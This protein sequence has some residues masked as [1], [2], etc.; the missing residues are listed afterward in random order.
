MIKEVEY[1]NFK[2]QTGVQELTG[3]DIFIGRNG[4]GKTSRIQSLGAALLGYVPGRDN[5]KTA[6][7]TFKFATGPIMAIGAKTQNGFRFYRSF[8]RKEKHEKDGSIKVSIAE[9][10]TVTPP[11]GEKTDTQ[12]KA[13]IAEEVGNFPVA[14]DFQEFLALSDT[15]RRDFIYSLSPIKTNNWTRERLERHLDKLLTLGLKTTNYEHYIVMV[16]MITE[17]MKQFPENYDFQAGLQAMVDWVAAQKTF[18]DAKKKDAQG[19]VRSMTD[20]KNETENTDRDIVQKK[21]ELDDLQ[22]QLIEVEK[23]ISTSQEQ[24]KAY[25]KRLKRI[26]DL[27]ELIRI[28]P[29]VIRDTKDL[30]DQISALLDQ[31]VKPGNIAVLIQPIKDQL[32]QNKLEH[33]GLEEK[34]RGLKDKI[35]LYET[36]II[37]LEQALAQTKELAG[38]CIVSPEYISCPKDF[39]GFGDW[40]EKK[41]AAAQVEIAKLKEE[42]KAL[43]E[44]I[45]ALEKGIK[46]LESQQQG[47]LQKHQDTLAANQK[48]QEQTTSLSSQKNERARAYQAREVNLAAYNAELKRLEDEPAFISVPIDILEKQAEGIRTNIADLKKTV[49]EKEKAKQAILLIQQSMVDNRKAEYKSLCLKSISEELG[50]KGVQGML[51][52]EILEPLREDIQGN[53]R[54]GGFDFTPYFQTKSDTG[55]DIFQF[56]WVNEK[57][58]QVNF[59]TLSTGQQVI[60]LAAL[61]LTIIDRAQPKTRM[62]IIDNVNHC[63]QINFQMLVD[64]LNKMAERA[65]NIILAGAVAF[66]VEAPAGWKVWDL[67]VNTE[68]GAAT[69]ERIA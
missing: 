39:T 17:A 62:L 43:T 7:D 61:M 28:M 20:Q 13:R 67:D 45:N 14:L 30:D 35:S 58:H 54:A 56:G 68:E 22:N 38:Q 53:L 47:V 11:K 48:I 1:K 18:W 26:E 66:K 24:K 27:K 50:P 49:E 21:Q 57:N 69:D 37:A 2:G 32:I 46:E 34:V 55:Q 60:Y 44:K 25:D 15:K 10:V 52:E 31:L 12:R 65:D 40:I 23:K 64:G 63:D 36:G 9:S 4:T 29:E 42:L 6:G 19:A 5:G 8:E 16:E 33:A 59:V 3:R 51:V 41:K